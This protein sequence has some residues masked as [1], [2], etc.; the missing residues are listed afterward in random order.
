VKRLGIT[1]RVEY[2]Q[3]YE[4]R[5]DCL[6][7]RWSLL[8]HQLGYLTLPLANIQAEMV[9]LYLDDLGLDAVL[10]SGGNTIT[11]LNPSADNAA[12]ERDAFE[13]ALIREALERDI[14]TIAVCRG[15]QMINIQMGGGL[16]PI[17]GHVAV[18]HPIVPSQ[19]DLRL[20]DTTNSY[21][22]WSISPGDLA[23]NLI[24]LAFDTDGN[25]EAFRHSDK[26]VLG[27]MWHPERE[28]P[29]CEL[30]LQLIKSYIP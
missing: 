29:F 18:R 28:Q 4:E 27:I 23:T 11:S 30:D 17:T 10:L 22:D 1:Q 5:R 3:S 19:T 15:M 25:I 24:P 21:H 20:P 6:D 13:S 12:P 2:V 16:S 14:P 9:P 7:Q 26:S 8:A